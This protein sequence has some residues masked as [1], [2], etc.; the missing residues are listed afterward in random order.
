MM[1]SA[2]LMA[3][4][5]QKP[6]DYK[7]AS[8]TPWFDYNLLLTEKAA[9]IDRQFISCNQGIPQSFIENNKG[10]WNYE[11]VSL[12]RNISAEFVK[13]NLLKM[14]KPWILSNPAFKLRHFSMLGLDSSRD[15]VHMSTNRNLTINDLNIYMNFKYVSALPKITLNDIISTS[16][17]YPWDMDYFSSNSGVTFEQ[18]IM[19]KDSLYWNHDFIPAIPEMPLDYFL[20][21]NYN[22]NSISSSKSLT[23]EHVIRY[24]E[25]FATANK[26]ILSQNS[27]ISVR[28]QLAYP[29]FFDFSYSSCNPTLKREDVKENKDKNWSIEWICAN[30]FGE[31]KD[32][33]TPY[34][35]R[36][37]GFGVY[38]SENHFE[39]LV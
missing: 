12:K 23:I 25:K 37:L 33:F 3:R 13:K 28:D 2:L 17:I 30:H 22:I 4:D 9:L 6:F 14:R 35:F 24:P 11:Y 20:V 36:D 21:N 19:H 1:R 7:M 27:G 10:L 38:V 29:Q 26:R 5:L 31:I 8:I 34:I 16:E 32:K 15:V 39:K 18:Y